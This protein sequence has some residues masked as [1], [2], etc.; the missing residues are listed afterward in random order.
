MQHCENCGSEL[1]AN[2]RYCGHCG[3]KIRNETE[4]T[5][6]SNDAPIEDIP[7][8]PLED[9][10]AFNNL[11]DSEL[12]NEE[13]EEQQALDLASENDVVEEEE[14][15]HQALENDEGRANTAGLY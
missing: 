8:S 2:A 14:T 12:E 1:R 13:E 11:Q 3:Q 7:V 4:V 6:I 10:T 9:S 15:T 5:T